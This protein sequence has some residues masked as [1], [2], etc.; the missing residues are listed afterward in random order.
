MERE[1][2]S[3]IA[4]NVKQE[5]GL[6]IPKKVSSSSSEKKS[7]F[8][9][10]KKVFKSALEKAMPSVANDCSI[11]IA[12]DYGEGDSEN[13]LHDP[14]NVSN[15]EF[16]RSQLLEEKLR[17]ALQAQAMAEE[18]LQKRE[19]ILKE[20]SEKNRQLQNQLQHYKPFNA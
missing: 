1:I 15:E 13:F 17:A 10:N 7:E 12:R 5:E 6:L 9:K 11:H 20:M 14:V 16:S 18:K 3:K 8:V 4:L 19:K 2:E